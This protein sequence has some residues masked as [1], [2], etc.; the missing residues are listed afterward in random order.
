M[1]KQ[2]IVD[3]LQSTFQGVED[4]ENFGYNFFFYGSDHTL[5]FVTIANSDNEYDSYSKLDAPDR[6]RLNI[7]VSKASFQRLIG[8][9][10]PEIG[11]YDFSQSDTIMPHPEYAAQSWIC[12]VKPS[13]HL[14]E[15]ELKP[16][17]QEAYD[18]ALQRAKRRQKPSE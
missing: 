7:G 2:Q 16:L 6:F 15:E 9:E 3:Y 4:S 1:E 11:S 12:V 10:K 17:I 5:P 18:L 14:F 13:E 8:S